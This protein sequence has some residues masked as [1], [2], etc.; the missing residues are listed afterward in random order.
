MDSATLA[1]N[2]YAA[3]TEATRTPREAEYDVLARCTHHL[4]LAAS[5]GRT[6]FA[7]LAQ[8]V[9]DN[10]TLW[11]ALAADVADPANGLPEALRARVFYLAQFT[12]L[13][14]QKVLA[15]SADVD[16]LVFINTAIMRGLRQDGA[17]A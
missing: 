11:T 6:G 14:S 7:A 17:A 9:H 2:A 16:P 1:R 4:R 12:A 15:G 13:H 10:R 5:K 8:A 3:P